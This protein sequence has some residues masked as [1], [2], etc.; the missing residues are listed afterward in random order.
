L[1]PFRI[2]QF[3]ID[4][5]PDFTF[6]LKERVQADLA[7]RATPVLEPAR[8]RDILARILKKLGRTGEDLEERVAS[9]PLLKIGLTP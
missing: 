5:H 3:E 7:A 9:S 8:R 4:T 6:H 1:I 2:R